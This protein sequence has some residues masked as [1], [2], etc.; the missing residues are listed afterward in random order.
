M[1][2]AG[3]LETK[4]QKGHTQRWA[5]EEGSAGG[6]RRLGGASGSQDGRLSRG[7]QRSVWRRLKWAKQGLFHLER[8]PATCAEPFSLVG[9]AEGDFQ[10]LKC[11][12]EV[13][14]SRGCGTF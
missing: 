11:D 14:S 6:G 4:L 2:R 13:R 12:Y 5:E 1:E 8:S 3:A 9:T 7:G 10:G